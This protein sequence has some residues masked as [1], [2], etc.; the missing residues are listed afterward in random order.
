MTE[1]EQMDYE[2]DCS[3]LRT[4]QKERQPTSGSDVRCKRLSKPA[5]CVGTLPLTREWPVLSMRA[6]CGTKAIPQ[7]V[8]ILQDGDR[9]ILL[10]DL[11]RV[12]E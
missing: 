12:Q 3:F 7:E 4:F 1:T 10:Q 8:S 9:T 2:T 11:L 6:F 5:D